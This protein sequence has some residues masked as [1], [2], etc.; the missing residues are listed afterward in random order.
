MPSLS[1]LEQGRRPWQRG[2][3]R[4]PPRTQSPDWKPPYWVGNSA[5]WCVPTGAHTSSVDGGC[6][7]TREAFS[8]AAGSKCHLF[9]GPNS[10]DPALPL[11]GPELRAILEGSSVGREWLGDKQ[12]S[13][14][15][16]A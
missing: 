8:G 16:G 7:D 3:V 14:A 13:T 1:Q 15:P 11:W 10:L 2:P 6:P 4:F 12:V 5:R 9:P